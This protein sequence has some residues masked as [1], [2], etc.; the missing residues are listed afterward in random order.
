MPSAA[1]SAAWAIVSLNLVGSDVRMVAAAP[2][3]NFGSAAISNDGKLVAFDSWPPPKFENTNQWIYVASIDGKNMHRVAK[4]AM[5]KWS[6]DDKSLAYQ[7]YVNGVAVVQRQRSRVTGQ[8][9]PC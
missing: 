8:W 7:D 4:G 1:S 2:E 9:N 6:P 3:L 5:P